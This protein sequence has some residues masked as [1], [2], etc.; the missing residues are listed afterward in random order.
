[1][2]FFIDRYFINFIFD[3]NVKIK[4]ILFYFY[5]LFYKKIIALIIKNHHIWTLIWIRHIFY[6]NQLNEDNRF[7]INT[8]VIETL[9]D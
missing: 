9:W 1:M 2:L 7:H 3:I 8:Y 4:L 5:M 6:T